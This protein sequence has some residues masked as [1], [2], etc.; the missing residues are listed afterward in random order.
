MFNATEVVIGKFQDYLR[1]C[2]TDAFG[3]MEPEYPNII[4]FIA[5]LAL[6][7][8]A[9]SD[10]PYHDMEHTIRVTD[11]GQTIL[12]GRHLLDGGIAPSDWLHVTVALLLHDIGYV[13]GVLPGDAK[14]SFVTD[15]SG[16][17][18]TLGE[19]ATDASLSIHHVNR[20]KLFVSHWFAEIPEIDVARLQEY[21]EMTRFP[22]PK[23]PF[24]QQ[25]DTLAGLVRAADLIGQMGDIS[26]RRKTAAL[27]RE[28]IEAASN[29]S[30]L[31]TTAHE[32]RQ[33]YP[34][35]FWNVVSPLIQP[36]LRY[37]HVT[38]EG[39]LWSGVLFSHVFAAEHM[40][41]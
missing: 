15:A 19:D 35:F 36:A 3:L 16:S 24:Y 32:L 9:N 39:K 20:G 4:A 21:I 2:Y 22:V 29:R 12:K 26:Y 28:L 18:V 41:G 14:N 6:E 10:A 13:R 25:T 30:P 40:L 27:H 17:I 34:A 5:R 37:L 33:N 38:Q 7:N 11:C 23:E 1:N 8:I 31:Y